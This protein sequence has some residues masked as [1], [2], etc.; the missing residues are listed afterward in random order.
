MPWHAI[1]YKIAYFL[2][3]F[4]SPSE[5]G[6]DGRGIQERGVLIPTMVRP[7]SNCIGYQMIAGHR[8]KFAS[9]LAK[10]DSISAIV[11]D[12]SD[13]EAIIIMVD[14]NI[15]RENLLPSERAYAYKMKYDELKHQGKRVDLTSD[16]LGPN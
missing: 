3:N 13:D 8:R 7:N 14:S 15:Q 12:Y 11:K 16:Q 5:Y 9:E 4:F 6:K 2:L 10:L 1:K